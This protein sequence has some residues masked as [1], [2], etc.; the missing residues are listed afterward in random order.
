MDDLTPAQLLWTA[1]AA[2]L[3]VAAASAW[4]EHRR[5]RRSNLD[6]PGLVPWNTIQVL[7]FLLAVAAATLALKAG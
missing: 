7:A 2:L 5:G 6:R 1:A 4:A 3:L